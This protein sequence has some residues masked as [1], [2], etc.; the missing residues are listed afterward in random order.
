MARALLVSCFDMTTLLSSN[1]KG[2]V[3][4]RSGADET[5]RLQ[6]LDE[7][8]LEAIYNQYDFFGRVRLTSVAAWG[9]Y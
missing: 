3:S 5:V 9:I 4:K 6:K 8:K 1:L 7:S 2:G